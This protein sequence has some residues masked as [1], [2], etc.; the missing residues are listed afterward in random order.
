MTAEGGSAPSGNGS[1]APSEVASS[2]GP[3]GRRSEPAASGGRRSIAA[4]PTPSGRSVTDLELA[5]AQNPESDAYVELCYAY[6]SKRRFMEAMVVCKK[7]ARTQS[8]ALLPK[9]MLARVHEAQERYPRAL[10]VLKSLARQF[11]Q[12]PEVDLA[13]GRV[14]LAAGDEAAGI[15]ALRKA[16]DREPALEEA[17]ELLQSKGI[18]YPEPPPAPVHS[19]DLDLPSG[20]PVVGLAPPAP[21][22]DP[23]H[24]AP[25]P[26]AQVSGIRGVSGVHL[27][28][29]VSGGML[30]PGVSGGMLPPGV[31]G[32]MLPPGVSGG[33]LPPGVSGGVLPPGMSGALGSQVSGVFRIPPVRLEGEDE[34]ERMAEENARAEPARGTPRTTFLLLLG[35]LV[36]SIGVVGFRFF[37]KSRLEAIDRLTL[38][39]LEAFDRDLYASYKVAAAR[40]E[41]ILQRYD[42]DHPA[43]LAR[44]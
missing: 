38:E 17:T 19:Q 18:T 24:G 36:I 21:G 26:Y 29:G 33:M 7:A 2:G 13:L 39:G 12:E 31:S 44:L 8:E 1:E 3:G 10:E 25:Q 37:E 4:A 22:T 34:L 20:V 9:L 11:P 14:Q 41:S 5:F 30:P 23:G 28:P 15:E 32:G 42:D 43:T 6:L 40:F 16:L 35:L 27:P